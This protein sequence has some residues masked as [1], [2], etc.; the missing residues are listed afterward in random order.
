MGKTFDKKVI[1]VVKVRYDAV[2]APYPYTPIINETIRDIEL[3]NEA[4]GCLIRGLSNVENWQG[5]LRNMTSKQDKT[6]AI[7]R[8]VHDLQRVGYVHH[9]T[10]KDAVTKQIRGKYYRFYEQ[11]QTPELDTKIVFVDSEGDR[12]ETKNTNKLRRIMYEVGAKDEAE[13]ISLLKEFKAAKSGKSSEAPTPSVSE[14][15]NEETTVKPFEM[16]LRE[17]TAFLQQEAIKYSLDSLDLT[18]L[19]NVFAVYDKALLHTE[20]EKYL[21]HF[22]KWIPAGLKIIAARNRPKRAT[23][24]AK[25]ATTP[26][27]A[28][29]EFTRL[30]KAVDTVDENTEYKAFVEK[31]DTLIETGEN[32]TI[33]LTEHQKEILLFFKGLKNTAGKRAEY[34]KQL[35]REL[36]TK[37]DTS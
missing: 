35:K 6:R 12:H 31:I 11:K 23:K 10:E 15:K 3:S 24:T 33:H 26:L 20:I 9:I 19:I 25:A 34:L 4:L 1:G 32:N 17:N 2:K 18:E 37:K 28:Q 5:N 21:S 27:A 7:T 8:Q 29:T 36:L 14:V 30:T 13:L 22:D 16:Q